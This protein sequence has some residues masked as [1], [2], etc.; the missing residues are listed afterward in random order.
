MKVLRLF[1]LLFC[2]VLPALRGAESFRFTSKPG[3]KCF[4]EEV[5]EAG[6]YHLYYKM[7]RSLTPFVAVSVTTADGRVVVEHHMA[8]A[9]AQEILDIKHER[10]L[11]ICF[12]VSPKALHSASSFNI[13]LELMDAQD[14]EFER[15][16]RERRS[17]SNPAALGTAQSS[18][19]LLQMH[20]IID[21]ATR[22]R[23]DFLSLISVDEDMRYSLNEVNAEAWNYVYLFAFISLL[24]CTVTYA[25]LR[26][27][28]KTKKY[29]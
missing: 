7:T 24:I 9:D 12:T 15:Q 21:M 25:R 5:P 4:T 10:K 6:R 26:H 11:A 27:F 3:K 23:F 19:S 29:I 22:I 14:A 28:F 16:R 8:R 18:G 13:T 1:L 20:Y 17:T 2:A